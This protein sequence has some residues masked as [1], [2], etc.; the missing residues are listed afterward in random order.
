MGVA[1]ANRVEPEACHVFAIPRTCKQTFE[2]PLVR[3]R[4]WVSEKLCKK[5]GL[6][7]QAGERECGSAGERATIGLRGKFQAPLRQAAG[8][9]MIDDD[10][11]ISLAAHHAAAG[12]RHVRP[13]LLVAA[14]LLDPG[15]QCFFLRYGE[16]LLEI[17]GRHRIVCGVDSLEH[18]ARSRLL[19]IDRPIPPQVCRGSLKRV[20]P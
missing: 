9:E 8:D 19:G 17:C 16:L 5:G 7:G 18:L 15:T 13:V 2:I 14:T 1:V 12:W 20:E 6:G 4:C 11:T 10:R 3:V